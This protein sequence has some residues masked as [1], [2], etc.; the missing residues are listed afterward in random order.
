VGSGKG[1]EKLTKRNVLS[2]IIL[3]AVNPW[4]PRSVWARFVLSHK[5]WKEAAK[6]LAKAGSVKFIK[7][8]LR[9]VDPL[10]YITLVT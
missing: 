3:S 8:Q 9:R 2:G 7:P 6:E 1:W 5:P 10:G 4:S